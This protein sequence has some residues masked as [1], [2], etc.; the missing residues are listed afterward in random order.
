M[1]AQ[2][3]LLQV[4]WRPAA[5][6]A[7]VPRKCVFTSFRRTLHT[8]RFVLMQQ[9]TD[10]RENGVGRAMAAAVAVG[11][12]RWVCVRCEGPHASA[13]HHAKL[14]TR[15]GKIT[16]RAHPA[17]YV[18]KASQEW[19]PCITGYKYRIGVTRGSIAVRSIHDHALDARLDELTQ[20]A[21]DAVC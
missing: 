8:P 14:R 18:L 2:E 20:R 5:E 13:L 3:R 21:S 7:T 1:G 12:M 15:L 6:S 9:L 17:T 10:W 11:E 19:L 4:L 16:S